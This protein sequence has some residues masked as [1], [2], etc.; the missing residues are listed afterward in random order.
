MA[1]ARAV[2]VIFGAV[3]VALVVVGVWAVVGPPAAEPMVPVVAPAP[4]A[5]DANGF[6]VRLLPPNPSGVSLDMLPLL[7]PGMSRAEVEDAVGLPNPA[8]V[9]PV[10]GSRGRATYHTAY[11]IA[12]A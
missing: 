3:L 7:Q 10:G 12:H 1:V 4:Q 11:P 6:R 9:Q 2:R 5:F 8:E